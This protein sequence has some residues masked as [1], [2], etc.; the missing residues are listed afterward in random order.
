[1]RLTKANILFVKEFCMPNNRVKWA[2][3]MKSRAMSDMRVYESPYEQLPK[4]VQ[5]FVADNP[6]KIVHHDNTY[7]ITEYIY[8]E[9]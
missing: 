5:K 9:V 1:M 3:V 4:T 7:D 8:M 2:V 6:W